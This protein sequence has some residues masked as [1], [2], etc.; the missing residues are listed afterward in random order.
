MLKS[1]KDIFDVLLLENIRQ[2]INKISM[3]D[4]IKIDVD[5]IARKLAVEGNI[6]LYSNDHDIIKDFKFDKQYVPE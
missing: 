5:D 4:L 2:E 3:T 1:N 6:N